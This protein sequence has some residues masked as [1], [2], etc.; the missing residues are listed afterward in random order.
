MA[1][2]GCYGVLVFGGTAGT[3]PPAL[4]QRYALISSVRVTDC[5]APAAPG[6]RGAFCTR[7]LTVVEACPDE[8]VVVAR[9]SG[10]SCVEAWGGGGGRFGPAVGGFLCLYEELVMT[11][12][13]VGPCVVEVE[14]SRLRCFEGSPRRISVERL[15]GAETVAGG[16]A[17]D[18]VGAPVGRAF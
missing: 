5:G 14:L 7:S 11:K 4:W 10:P 8:V 12:L 17:G 18:V 9:V 1:G 3:H 13:S 2:G 15:G 16:G 6:G